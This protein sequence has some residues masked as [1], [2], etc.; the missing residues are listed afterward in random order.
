[1]KK[2]M[3]LALGL[4]LLAGSAF[5]APNRPGPDARN[6]GRNE[7]R[8]DRGRKDGRKDGRHDDRRDDRRG[9]RRDDGR[10]R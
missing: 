4:S 7:A 8:N 6:R 3:T 1:M 10:R 9:G 2:M 5:A